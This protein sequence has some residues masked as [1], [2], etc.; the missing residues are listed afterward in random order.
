MKCTMSSICSVT[1]KTIKEALEFSLTREIA[2]ACFK[3][4]LAVARAVGYDI[5]ETYPTQALNYLLK[6]GVHRDSIS[7]DIENKTPTEIDFLAG[8]IVSYAREKGV[9]TPFC[10]H[11]TYNEYASRLKICTC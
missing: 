4:A 3:E 11:S 9:S 1:N 8:K 6:A 7:F 2:E 10:K 5:E